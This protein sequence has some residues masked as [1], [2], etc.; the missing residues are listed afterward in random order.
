MFWKS[1]TQVQVK[2]TQALPDPFVATHCLC[3]SLYT[4][5]HKDTTQVVLKQCSQYLWAVYVCCG[6]P[7]PLSH[8]GM[9]INPNY[10]STLH[11]PVTNSYCAFSCALTCTMCHLSHSAIIHDCQRLLSLDC[12]LSWTQKKMSLCKSK[13]KNL[14]WDLFKE[15]QWTSLTL[16]AILLRLCFQTY[17]KEQWC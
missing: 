15:Q 14:V 5:S 1:L 8:F 10:A 13:K 16:T 6:R 9:C 2:P 3:T 12:G 7:R 17:P 4:S 11:L